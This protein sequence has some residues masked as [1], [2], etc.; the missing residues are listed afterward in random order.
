MRITSTGF[1]PYQTKLQQ[2]KNSE[3][4]EKESAAQ[5]NVLQSSPAATYESTSKVQSSETEALT[6]EQKTENFKN[7]I[8]NKYKDYGLTFSSGLTAPKRGIAPSISVAPQLLEQA[9]N[10]PQ[11]AKEVDEMIY[12]ATMIDTNFFNAM[13]HSPEVTVSLSTHIN[14]DGSSVS[15]L[16][17]EYNSLEAKNKYGGFDANSFLDKQE[18]LLKKRKS[19]FDYEEA[20]GEKSSEDYTDDIAEARWEN[21]QWLQEFR[22]GLRMEE[23]IKDQ[24]EEEYILQQ[25]Q[26]KQLFDR[27]I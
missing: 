12:A 6:N 9:V 23:W 2:A 19:D 27:K 20:V 11:K 5:A 26:Q 8:L 1:N 21:R 7:Y 25:Q 15:I 17:R 4:P 18:E 24:D 10:D 3:T 22:D 13:N 16:S 14:A